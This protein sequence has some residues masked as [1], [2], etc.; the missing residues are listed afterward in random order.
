MLLPTTCASMRVHSTSW[1]N[2]T[3][4]AS[5]I[6]GSTQPGAGKRLNVGAREYRCG[7][8]VSALV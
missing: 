2:A 3:A 4:P 6:S 7:C 8:C 1:K 5:S